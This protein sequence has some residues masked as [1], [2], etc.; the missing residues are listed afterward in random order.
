[1]H[2]RCR[3]TKK[4]GF[5]DQPKDEAKREN[6]KLFKFFTRWAPACWYYNFFSF[7][8]FVLWNCHAHHFDDEIKRA[9]FV[10]SIKNLSGC[11]FLLGKSDLVSK[12]VVNLLVVFF[13][14][15]VCGS[16]RTEDF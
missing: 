9:G 8:L 6:Q 15:H 10:E 13:V 7:S 3:K 2:I 5:E 4:F 16:L 12:M 1:L 14:N 11:Q